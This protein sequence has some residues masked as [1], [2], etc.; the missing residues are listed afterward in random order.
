MKCFNLPLLP[1]GIYANK[2]RGAIDPPCPN[3]YGPDIDLQQLTECLATCHNFRK[4]SLGLAAHIGI[5][6]V[7]LSSK[8]LLYIF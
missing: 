5:K 2:Y 1:V 7:K 4:C 3:S 6:G 8:S